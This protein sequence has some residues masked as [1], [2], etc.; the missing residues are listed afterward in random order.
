MERILKSK[1]KILD[2]VFE[3]QAHV[4]YKGVFTDSEK[5]LIIKIFKREMLNSTLIKSI[6]KEVLPLT[7]I[8]HQRIPRLY[9]GDYGWQGYYFVRD[10]V[11]GQCLFET[12]LPLEAEEASEIVIQIAEILN[13]AHKMGLVHGSL[14]PGNIFVSGNKVLVCDF[15]IKSLVMGDIEQRPYLLAGEKAS[16]MAP[17]MILGEGPGIRSDIFQAGLLL[18]LMLTGEL[19]DNE[20]TGFGRASAN[21]NADF[22]PPSSVNGKVPRYLDE[23]VMFCLQKDPALR[24][25]SAG[26]LADSLKNKALML[27]KQDII[28]LSDIGGFIPEEEKREPVPAIEKTEERIQRKNR[29]AF[30]RWVFFAIWAAVAA[31]I[32]YSL[33][34]I[35][36]IGE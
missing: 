13:E 16:F 36:V 21:L 30:I 5:P 27:F 8:I 19:P 15:K 28:D 24:F 26:Q 20:R 35:F 32:I 3:N 9:D 25:Q 10:F 12:K 1:Y 34:Q 14:T 18:Y 4:T 29:P 23:I 17:E 7:R 6:T 33:I 22:R 31:G 11:E 2:K